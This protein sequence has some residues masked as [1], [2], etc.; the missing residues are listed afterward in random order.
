M[1]APR[2]LAPT[3]IS[4]GIPVSGAGAPNTVALW[5]PDGVTLGNSLL[6]QAG[7]II[8][9][10]SGAIRA[11]GTSQTSP[12]F[13]WS[14]ATTNTGIYFPGTNEIGFTINGG[15]AM[16]IGT[17]R[18]IGIGTVSPANLLTLTKGNASGLNLQ[19]DAAGNA[20]TGLFLATRGSSSAIIAGGSE[21]ADATTT[22]R[23]T[24]AS[25]VLQDSGLIVFYTNTGLVSGNTFAPTERARID[26]SGNVGIGTASPAALL[27][28]FRSGTTDPAIIGAGSNSATGNFESA[29]ASRTNR[30]TFGRDNAVTGNFVLAYNGSPFINTTS[31]GNVGIGTVSPKARGDVSGTNASQSDWGLLFVNSNDA[32]GADKGGSVSFGGLYQAGTVTHWAQVSGRKENGTSGEY[33]GYLAFAT[34]TNGAGTNAERMRIDSSG[35]VGIATTPSSWSSQYRA[36][37]L[38]KGLSFMARDGGDVYINQNGIYD[39]GNAWKYVVSGTNAS[40]QILMSSGVV[41]FSR[42]VAGAAGAALTWVES[43][44]IDSSGV[45]VVGLGAASSD[46]AN[47]LQLTNNSTAKQGVEFR[48]GVTLSGGTTGTLVIA[49]DRAASAYQG[50][51]WNTTFFKLPQNNSYFDASASGGGLKLPATNGTTYNTDPNTLDCYAEK[52]L[53]A[54]MTPGTSGTITLSSSTL[55]F[56]RIGR[57][58][59]IVGRLVI[60]SVSSP[61]GRLAINTGV[62]ANEYPG[63]YAAAAVFPN[64]WQAGFTG[65]PC[66]VAIPA[67]AIVYLDRFTTGGVG[68]DVASYAQAGAEVTISLTY[69]L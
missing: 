36:L 35:N 68:I 48:P 57:V 42:A 50:T 67:S 61:V 65:A 64:G 30:W 8:T 47:R 41:S 5:Q 32:F 2:L 17:T 52:D 25:A 27:H 26:S 44:R 28:V 29:D 18:N 12:A 66:A 6:T 53:T 62:G 20:R 60:G 38:N 13:A 16:Y 46:P 34:R 23:S 3:T 19:Y 11:S 49:Y 33:G 45:L 43:A 10:S 9:N 4:G 21:W 14:G 54:T 51:D 31:T 58:V 56:T 59:T 63:T 22:A 15:H 7:S 69:T 1:G 55:K 37:Q 24:A 40:S 39:S